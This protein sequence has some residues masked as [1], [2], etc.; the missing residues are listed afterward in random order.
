MGKDRWLQMTTRLRQ[1]LDNVV[2]RVDNVEAVEKLARR[3]GEE[4][5]EL[6]CY[7]FKPDFW[8]SL[9]DAMTVECV[10]LDQATHQPSDTITA[11]SLLVSLM[12]SAVRDGYYQA[13]RAQRISQRH[14]N[15]QQ[16]ELSLRLDEDVDSDTG[17]GRSFSGVEK[18]ASAHELQSPVKRS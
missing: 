13:M 12:F 7:G 5:V 9:A 2:K 4:H 8:V 18:S 15:V 14:R 16:R 1:F 6:K 17:G 3:Y 10:I 11:W